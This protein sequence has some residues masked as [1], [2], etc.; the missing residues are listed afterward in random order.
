[1][2]RARANGEGTIYRR[3]D[4][5]YEGAAYF[6]TTSGRRKRL[7]VYGKTREEVHVNLTNAKAKAQQGTPLPDQTWKL[8]DYLHYWLETVVRTNRRRT[9]YSRYEL[10]VRMYLGQG[11]GK[12]KLSQLSVPIVQR[13]LNQKLEEGCSIRNVHI[14]RAVLS[15][16]LTSAQREEFVSR[17]VARLVELPTY[18]PD[19][20][21]PWSADE[22]RKFLEAASGDPLYVAFS[23]LVLCGL[24]RG[25]VLGLRWRDIDFGKREIYIRQQLQRVNGVLYQAPV[26][27][28]AGRRDLPLLG[29]AR[30]LL[31]SQHIRQ[32]ADRNRAG[33]TWLGTGNTDEL[34]FT[35]RSGRPVEP[36]NFSRSF[37][38]ICQKKALR[39]IRMHDVRHTT[40]TLLK[41]LGVP[42]RDAQLILGHSDIST[43]QGV[44]Q[45]DD[46]EH[47]RNSL[48]QVE[49]LFVNQIESTR[50]R[51]IQPSTSRYTRTLTSSTSGR[52]GGIRTPDPRFWSSTPPTLQE[53]LTSIKLT[54]RGRTSAWM[55]GCVAV[56]N[57]RQTIT[58]EQPSSTTAQA[59]QLNCPECQC[60]CAG[61][62]EHP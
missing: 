37:V 19:E 41:N 23:L 53:H 6:L 27:T 48:R 14:M 30:A 51:Q 34:V 46:M 60:R 13:F 42:A 7:R 28:K 57:S 1:M 44:Y 4:G 62:E 35:S 58:S 26:K 56:S 29:F 47:R 43:T 22:A 16:A 50:C 20:I 2:A 55:L 25:E 21:K 18:E 40:A 15:A 33:A 8:G 52:S 31:I 10:I 24:R 9:T 36:R 5:R 3:K 49:N 54:M 17:N 39:K 45:H 32:Q 61:I 38:Y 12:H 59:A 11:F